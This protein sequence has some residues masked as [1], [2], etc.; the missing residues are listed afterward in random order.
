MTATAAPA[1]NAELSAAL[2]DVV[3][4]PSGL[5]AELPGRTVEADSPTELRGRLSAAL[6]DVLHTGRTEDGDL[7]FR[8]RD[9]E[10]EATFAAAVGHRSTTRQ[11]VVCDLGEQATDPDTLLV[12]CDGVRIWVSAKDIRDPGPH[13]PGSVVTVS[14][15]A[16]RPAVSPGFFL[17]TASE[18]KPVSD[19]LLRMYLHVGTPEDAAGIWAAT[20]ARL[21]SEVDGYQAKVLSARALYPRRASIVVYLSD[22]DT[23]LPAQLATLLG[24]HPGLLP[25][26]SVFTRRLAPGIAIAWEPTDPRP[27]MRG[28]SFGQHRAAVLARALVAAAI[29][30]TERD[31]A[32]ADAF[33]E[34]GIDPADPSRNTTSP[35]L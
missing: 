6:Y 2:D 25:G 32:V 13:L 11:V 9:P 29:D 15:P 22:Q 10:L 16:L 34:A 21:E 7:P 28:L 18:P 30:G 31:E 33:A 35:A 12:L 5:V 27:E 24:D 26:T 8:L 1:L 14:A 4:A 3:I 20:V 19:R 17:V 23:H